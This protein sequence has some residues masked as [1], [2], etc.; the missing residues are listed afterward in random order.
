MP[1]DTTTIRH[2][3]PEDPGV[4]DHLRP[5]LFGGPLD[6]SETWRFLAVG[7]NEMVVALQAGQ[8]V[9][10]ATGTVLMRPDG[11]PSFLITDLRVHPDERRKGLG[12]R[13]LERL[14]D[15]A[16]DRGCRDITCQTEASD[17][18]A[19]ALCARLGARECEGRVSCV[20]T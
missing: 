18:A 10:L 9:G 2:L 17:D 6:P 7:L 19:R 11:P 4:L 3:G 20:W 5:G 15:V 8:V 14:L 16:T 12:M 13:L 1:G